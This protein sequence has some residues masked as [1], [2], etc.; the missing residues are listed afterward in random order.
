MEKQDKNNIKLYFLRNLAMDKEQTLYIAGPPCSATSTL[1]G[2]LNCHPDIFI[3]FESF[4]TKSRPTK[5]GQKFIKSYP[6]SRDLFR[7][8]QDFTSAYLGLKDFLRSKGYNYKLVGDK[9]AGLELDLLKLLEGHRVISTVRDIRTW[10]AKNTVIDFYSLENDVVPAAIDYSVYFLESFKLQR[11]FQIKMVD[12]IFKNKQV[13]NELSGFLRMELLPY[14][15]NWWD[16]VENFEATGPKGKIKW[17][18]RHHSATTKPQFKD[19]EVKIKPHPFWD[20]LLPI[21]DK[22]YNSLNKP[23]SHDDINRDIISLKSLARFSPVGLGRYLRKSPIY[24][25]P[26][27]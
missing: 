7:H 2:M 3:L 15:D 27:T 19:T 5:Y 24:H 18:L 10:L 13:I 25:Y 23:F 26:E 17:W 16:K 14:L 8:N 9:F 20:D 11:N 22:Y 6:E 1:V 4:L 21:F 12:L